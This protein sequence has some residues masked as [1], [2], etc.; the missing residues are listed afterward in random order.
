MGSVSLPFVWAYLGLGSNLGD[1]K[2]ALAAAVRALRWMP[3][4]NVVRVSA[5]YRTAPVGYENQPDFLNQVVE[6]QTGLGPRE[7][8]EQT[9]EIEREAGRARAL[10]WGPRTLD[11]DILW[12]D[13]RHVSEQGLQIPHPRIEERRFVLEP[14]SELVPD[15]MLP[16]GR[17]VWEAAQAAADQSVSRLNFG[18]EEEL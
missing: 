5:F 10:R 7:L 8:L 11:I 2:E 15:L 13:D 17:R 6:V 16:S 4:V 12:Y 9:Q 3:R 18:P 1:S 14:W